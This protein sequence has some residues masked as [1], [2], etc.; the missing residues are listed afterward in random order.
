LSIV[1]YR[2]FPEDKWPP[3]RRLLRRKLCESV[4]SS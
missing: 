1:L 4:T 3:P 2:Q